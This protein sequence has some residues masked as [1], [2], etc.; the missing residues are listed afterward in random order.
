MAITA[1]VKWGALPQLLWSCDECS[2]GQLL[3]QEMRLNGQLHRGVFRHM[4]ECM[5]RHSFHSTNTN[6]LLSTRE[7]VKC[8]VLYAISYSLTTKRC[9]PAKLPMDGTCI[10]LSSSTEFNLNIQEELPLVTKVDRCMY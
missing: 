9:M 6:I 8:L 10:I 3:L 7:F 1:N 4:L 5:K 2:F